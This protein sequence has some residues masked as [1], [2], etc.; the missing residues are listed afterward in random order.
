MLFKNA[1]IILGMFLKLRSGALLTK[2]DLFHLFAFFFVLFF[3]F[4]SFF[5]LYFPFNLP[6]SLLCL[7]VSFASYLSHSLFLFLPR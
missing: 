1:F 2:I 3:F 4:L 7:V 5:R 6:L